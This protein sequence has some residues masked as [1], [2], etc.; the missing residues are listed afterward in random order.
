MTARK[1]DE[2]RV[3]LTGHVDHGKSTVLGR[4]L[5]ECGALPD[6]K[7]E[8]IQAS[9][10]RHSKPFEYAFLIDALKEERS[11][12]VTIDSARVFFKTGSREYII[13]DSPG[14]IDFLRNMVTGASRA[15][16]A[17]LVIDADEGIKLNSRNHALLLSML[18][19]RQVTVV[20]NKMDLVGYDEARFSE[21]RSEY[22]EYLEK[23]GLSAKTFCPVSGLEGEN[24]T[25][26]SGKMK[27]F[28]GK[29]FLEAFELF[30]PPVPETEK[31]FRMPVQGVYKFT[32]GG[33]KRRIIAG[34]PESGS[35]RAG[36]EVV[37]YPSGKKARVRTLEEFN[38]APPEATEP[39][40]AAG[41]TLDEQ[42]FI[43]RGEVAASSS[44]TPPKVATRIKASLFWLGQRELA[45]GNRYLF[46]LGTTRVIAEVDEVLR[47][48]EST[49]IEKDLEISSVAA[50]SFAE[51]ILRLERPVALD[52]AADLPGTGRFVL[53]EDSSIA[54][55]GT[56]TGVL[57][58]EYGWV[59]DKTVIRDLKWERSRI[60]HAERCAK[61]RQRPAAV[62]ITGGKDTGKKPLAKALER[63]LFEKGHITYFLGIGNLLYGVDADIKGLTGFEGEHLRRLAEVGHIMLD[64][65]M[66][67]IVTAIGLTGDDL[68]ILRTA[69]GAEEMI[70]VWMGPSKPAELDADL[71]LDKLS[72]GKGP[73]HG[74]VLGILKERGIIW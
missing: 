51:C 48:F 35:I 59:R 74:E 17:F 47:V 58:D 65:G 9:C 11:Q 37:F 20:V 69:L 38:A 64:A 2:L 66:V 30:T 27:W 73:D 28:K 70:T 16:A 56:I 12:G 24:I 34:T 32:A 49:D 50:N 43:T 8:Q 57:K 1:F 21:I 54:G 6:G 29:S 22:G 39:G 33:D 62:F 46:K 60:P 26:S 18:G 5:A 63:A 4:L 13:I 15:D 52:P 36:D 67:L 31:P 42:L 72:A 55:G 68:G 10:R 45:E 41:M 19:I 7:L 14:H 25:R 3:V 44:G 53:V 23:V 40:R 61:F 71:T